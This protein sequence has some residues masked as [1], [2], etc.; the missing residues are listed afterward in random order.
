MSMTSVERVIIMR[1]IQGSGKS[2]WAVKTK[3]ELQSN[4]V[5]VRICSADHA[6]VNSDGNYEFIPENAGEAHLKCFTSFLFYLQQRKDVEDH[7]QVVIVDNT[8]IGLHEMTPYVQLAKSHGVPV[9]EIVQMCSPLDMCLKRQT[10]GVPEETVQRKYEELN[11]VK[12]PNW[13]VS[14]LRLVFK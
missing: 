3:C 10:H 11:S 1:G 13:L 12:I 7:P 8:N 6:H 5:Q 9:I 4:G 14:E 2:T